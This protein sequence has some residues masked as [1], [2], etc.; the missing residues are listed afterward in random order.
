[1]A[2]DGQN[3]EY[4]AIFGK[5]SIAKLSWA[6]LKKVP[7]RVLGIM[8]AQSLVDH[9]T[10]ATGLLGLTLEKNS[11]QNRNDATARNPHAP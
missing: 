2:L 11:S 8:L 10:D 9:F 1:M 6:E 7:I 4:S 5:A 3:L